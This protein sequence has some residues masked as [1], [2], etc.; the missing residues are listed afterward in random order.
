MDSLMRY[1][2][3]DYMD[4]GENGTEEYALM[5]VGFNS[6]DESPNAQVD[7]KAYIHEK[8]S[9]SKVKGYE[10]QFPYKADLVKDERVVMKVYEIARNQKTGI[11]A[12]VNYVRVELFKPTTGQSGVFAARKF[13][14]AVEV[15]DITGEGAN[16]LE[17]SGNLNQVG[18]FIDGQFN[19]DTKKFT[20]AG[21]TTPENE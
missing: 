6:L 13:R 14:T 3:S 8:V 16:P 9:S 20:A 11:D 2:V 19:V 18:E 10:G 5:G 15:S 21:E 12:E 7:K 1:D 4:V 17:M